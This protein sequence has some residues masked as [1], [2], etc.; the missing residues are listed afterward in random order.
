MSDLFVNLHHAVRRFGRSA[1]RRFRN[2]RTAAPSNRR[3]L[4]VPSGTDAPEDLLVGSGLAGR[5]S[6]RPILAETLSGGSIPEAA[7]V[8]R[9][10]VSQHQP[11]VVPTELQLEIHQQ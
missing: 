9:Q 3:T 4:P 5:A 8:R 1:V 10:L 2:S 7:A 11:A 6:A